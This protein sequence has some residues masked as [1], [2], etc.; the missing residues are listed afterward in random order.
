MNEADKFLV[1]SAVDDKN[2]MEEAYKNENTYSNER[3]EQVLDDIIL[4]IKKT[5]KQFS[6]NRD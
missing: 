4:F 5:Q 3:V 2:D 1:H 6:A